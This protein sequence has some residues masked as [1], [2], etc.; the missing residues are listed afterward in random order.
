MSN[1]Y[2]P[3]RIAM[4][5]TAV[6]Y[7]DCS[8]YGFMAPILAPIFL[9]NTDYVS[10][11][12]LAFGISPI[13]FIF[14]MLGAQYLG[15]IGDKEGRK[16]ALTVSII[17]MA[18]TTG[19]IGILP[20]YET[21]GIAAPII[22]FFSKMMESFFVAGEYNGG[23]IYS[24]EHTPE[25]KKGRISGIYCAYTV[26]GI[27]AAALAAAVVSYLPPT[28]WRLPFLLGFL[29]A[30]VGLIMRRQALE[31]PD[32]EK[33]ESSYKPRSLIEIF[34]LYQGE[35][36]CA[37][38]AAT[39][40]GAIYRIPSVFLN[41]FVPLVTSLSTSQVLTIN[42]GTLFV[43][44]FS[45]PV[46]GYLADKVGVRLVMMSGAMAAG[47]ISIP[48]FWAF[49]F[50]TIGAVIII[51]SIFSILTAW[52]VGPYHAYV[53]NLFPARHRYQM[54]SLTFS[55]GGKIGGML[56]AIALTIWSSTGLMIAPG[57]FVAFT[58]ILGLFAVYYGKDFLEKEPQSLL[59]V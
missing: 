33:T 24:L 19:I 57:I 47:L 2:K 40:F 41:A 38:G 56:P 55:L 34:K 15:K 7:Y 13:G 49:K 50:D 11:L 3:H 21:I 17:G 1:A 51:K 43:Y 31:T 6:E 58:G 12:I 52:F 14:R 18:I 20:T 25:G 46:F 4:I 22:F 36:F 35:I 9:P 28:Y 44:M 48:L 27:I 32:F 30:L 5:G 45:L 39:F 29:T 16:K 42:V 26:S 54:I 8:L 10:A 37:V 59:K 53:Q 23:A